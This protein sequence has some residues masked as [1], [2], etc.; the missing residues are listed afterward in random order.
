MRKFITTIFILL[1]LG[2]AALFFGW[3]Q[4]GV[5]PD[6]YGIIRSKTHG[7][8]ERLI[9]PGEFVWLWYRLIPTNAQTLVF[10]LGTV[11]H[12][13]IARDTL[14]SGAV[15]SAFAGIGGDF[16]WELNAVFSFSLKPESL[17]PLVTSHNFSGQEELDQYISD[18]AR[19]IENFLLRRMDSSEEFALQVESLLRY[20]ESAGLE[21]EVLEH[22]THIANFSIQVKSAVVPDFSLYS[23]V[24][25]LHGEYIALQKE[26][27]GEVLSDRARTRAETAVRFGE[28]EMYGELLTRFPVLLDFLALENRR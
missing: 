28:L 15:Y 25:G 20:G 4:M 21:Q 11:S 2:G 14:P 9:R 8:E 16:S 10:R 24:K 27:L 18:T 17:I 19:Q 23:L 7:T 1:L 13:F 12:E 26:Q 3:A 6:S 5:P 22:F